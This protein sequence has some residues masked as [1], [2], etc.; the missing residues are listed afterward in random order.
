LEKVGGDQFIL[1]L[2]TGSVS[3]AVAAWLTTERLMRFQV[4]YVTVPLGTA[5]D[6]VAYFDHAYPAARASSSR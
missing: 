1:A 5:F 4:G 3:P 6:A 2:H